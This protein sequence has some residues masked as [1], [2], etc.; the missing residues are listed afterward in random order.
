MNDVRD[1]IGRLMVTHGEENAGNKNYYNETVGIMK[2]LM[3]N[4][5]DFVINHEKGILYL[6][7]ILNNL[8]RTFWKPDKHGSGIINWAL[9]NF[10]FA[11]E[12]E[13]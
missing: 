1:L 13:A 7:R 11:R 3:R 10:T 8:P 12:T 4:F 6:I 9:N 5:S 2:M